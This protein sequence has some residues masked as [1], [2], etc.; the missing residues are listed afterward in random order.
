VPATIERAGA[1]D[2]AAIEEVVR[3]AY[4]KYVER[5]GRPPGPMLEDYR[6]RV[7][8]NAVWVLRDAGQIAGVLVLLPEPGY[9]QLDNVAIDP[10]AQGRGH[11]RALIA[12]AEAEARRL[13]Y[14]ELRLYTNAMMH[15]NLA[16]YPRLGFSETHRAREAGYD[17]VYFKKRV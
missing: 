14:E 5:I 9:L 1:A 11:G 2:V 16:L 8:E 10:G 4:T 13:G 7:A 15:E 17:R 6:A 3:R 12:F